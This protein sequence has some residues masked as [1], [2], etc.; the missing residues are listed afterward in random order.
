LHKLIGDVAATVIASDGNNVAGIEVDTSFGRV[1]T[2]RHGFC[3]E[4]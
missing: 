3:V 2:A 1:L 4:N